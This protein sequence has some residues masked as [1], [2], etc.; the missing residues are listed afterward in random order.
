[1]SLQGTLFRGPHGKTHFIVDNAMGRV[2]FDMDD[3][4][5]EGQMF[6]AIG[7]F[8]QVLNNAGYHVIAGWD[9]KGCGIFVIQYADIKSD[10]SEDHIEVL[11]EE[12]YQAVKMYRMQKF[13][14]L[15]SG[16]SN[17]DDDYEGPFTA[18]L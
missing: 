6:V 9:D 18:E 4:E 10:W 15:T 2:T 12:E 17:D 16:L 11:N 14:E 5:N 13:E 8:I 7:Q 1:M 3:Y